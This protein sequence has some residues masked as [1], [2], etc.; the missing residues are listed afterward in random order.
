[1]MQGR[2]DF[3]RLGH[4]KPCHV[5]ALRVFGSPH[6]DNF[7]NLVSDWAFFGSMMRL[8]GP[9]TV[10]DRE[11]TREDLLNI[12]VKDMGSLQQR[13]AGFR[14]SA[15]SGGRFP[16]ASMQCANAVWKDGISMLLAK[17]GLVI[18][19]LSGLSEKNRG[20]AYEITRIVDE[21]SLH[22]VIMLTDHS[23][24]EKVLQEILHET[25]QSLPVSSPNAAQEAI[26]FQLL[27][28]GGIREREPTESEY[29]WRKRT[30]IQMN[31][32]QLMCYLLAVADK[33]A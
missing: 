10:D 15:D 8:D 17:A 29:D 22:R 25:C 28:T 1:M 3:I 20:I 14:F 19:D 33:I 18:M 6:L 24:D 7:L 16:L 2:T 9:D 30:S 4:G 27:D 12:I 31:S 5:L 23:T 11:H 13:M 32:E 21:V 26:V